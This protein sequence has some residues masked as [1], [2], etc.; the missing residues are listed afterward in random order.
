MK[1][2]VERLALTMVKIQ[3]YSEEVNKHLNW[4][5]LACNKS[6]LEVRGARTT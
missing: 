4:L 5:R 2:I 3:D 6:S 1:H